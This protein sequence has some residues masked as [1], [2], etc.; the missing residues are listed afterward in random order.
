MPKKL[1]SK[2]HAFVQIKP[3]FIQSK[4]RVKIFT[5]NR[6]EMWVLLEFKKIKALN[7]HNSM[8]GSVIVRIEMFNRSTVVD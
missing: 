2:G 3:D 7:T 6:S 8:K 1:S 4:E 5:K